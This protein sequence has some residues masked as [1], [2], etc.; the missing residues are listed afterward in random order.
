MRLAASVVWAIVLLTLGLP[1]GDKPIQETAHGQELRE[2]RKVPSLVGRWKLVGFER[3]GI[4][5]PQRPLPAGSMS[6]D[7]DGGFTGSFPDH[8]MGGTFAIDPS[9]TP[10]TV[11]FVH[12]KEPDKGKPMYAIYKLEG[13]KLTLCAAPPGKPATQRPTT[14]ATRDTDNV[15]FIFEPVR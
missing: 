14:F 12:A 1:P 11:D 3:G 9:K 10:A 6:F 4:G 2:T 15:L 7:K 8:E 5:Q 13:T